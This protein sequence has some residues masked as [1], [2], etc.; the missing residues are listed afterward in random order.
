[1]TDIYLIR[2]E[3]QV[4]I[5]ELVRRIKEHQ[6]KYNELSY[7]TKDIVKKEKLLKDALM[8][9]VMTIAE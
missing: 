3:K 8:R 6:V 4:A 5:I 7:H 9:L 1:M 2:R